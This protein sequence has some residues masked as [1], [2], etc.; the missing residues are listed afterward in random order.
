LADLPSP[1][2]DFRA[3]RAGRLRSSSFWWAWGRGRGI[4]GLGNPSP[5]SPLSI[6]LGTT[7]TRVPVRVGG[8]HHRDPPPTISTA[9]AVV[10]L[11]IDR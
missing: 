3:W 4:N 7:I 6:D 1:P 5:F 10:G 9:V 2:N 8:K 11:G